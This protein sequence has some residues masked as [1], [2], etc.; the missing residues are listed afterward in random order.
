[1][2]ATAA[3]FLYL[4]RNALPLQLCPCFPQVFSILPFLFERRFLCSNPKCRIFSY[5]ACKL[6]K[7]L[8]RFCPFPSANLALFDFSLP[9]RW[10]FS[11]ILFLHNFNFVLGVRELDGQ[12][13]P[14]PNFQREHFVHFSLFMSLHHLS[15]KHHTCRFFGTSSLP[16]RSSSFLSSMFQKNRK[17]IS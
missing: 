13:D 3:F 5:L 10:T 16:K 12:E 17:R 6:K 4:C 2:A 9:I 1:M 15:L 11:V 7:P 14:G 8:F